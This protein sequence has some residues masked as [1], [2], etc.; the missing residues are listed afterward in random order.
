MKKANKGQFKKLTNAEVIK[1]IK[2]IFKNE[3]YS[4]ES[5]KY[6]TAQDLISKIFCLKRKITGFLRRQT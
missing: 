6:I 5:V 3:N 2:K 4:Y 1:R